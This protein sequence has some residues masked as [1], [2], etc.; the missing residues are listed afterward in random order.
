MRLLGA[1]HDTTPRIA[2]P[3]TG[4]VPPAAIPVLLE[5]AAAGDTGD[6][7]EAAIAD[8][9]GREVA[10]NANRFDG[11]D[12]SVRS[13]CVRVSDGVVPLGLRLGCRGWVGSSARRVYTYILGAQASH[14]RWVMEESETRASRPTRRT[15]VIAVVAGLVVLVLLFPASGIEPQPPVCYSVFGYVVPCEAWFA[16]LAG[17]ATAVLIGLALRLAHRRRQR[18]AG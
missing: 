14:P 9:E 15:A 18:S 11:H 8:R 16:W 1:G 17:V 7:C 12:V 2:V 3:A 5:A 6:R 10:L 4:E 13:R